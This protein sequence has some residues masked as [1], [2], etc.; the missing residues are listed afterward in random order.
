VRRRRYQQTPNPASGLRRVGGHLQSRAKAAAHGSDQRRKA[1][2]RPDARR[3]Q[4]N[5]V[6]RRGHDSARDRATVSRRQ[7]HQRQQRA[8]RKDWRVIQL[9]RTHLRAYRSWLIA[10]LLLQG[11]QAGASLLL[12]SLNADII[13]KG[14]LRGDT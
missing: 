1:A 14:V 6:R 5:V 8:T 13:D 4:S 11:V 12:P 2:S 10:V 9:L 3:Q 7:S